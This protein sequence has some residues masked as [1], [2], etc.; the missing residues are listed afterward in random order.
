VVAPEL[1][2]PVVQVPGQGLAILPPAILVARVET[3]GIDRIGSDFTPPFLP[4]PFHFMYGMVNKAVKDMVVAAHGE[5]MWQAIK[6]RASVTQEVFIGNEGYPD[7]LTYALVG[8]ASE[9]LE[10]P[11]PVIL[12]AFG[13]HWVL[14]TAAEGYGPMMAAGGNSLGEFLDNLPHF[15]DRVALIYPKLVPP[16]FEVTERTARSLRLH[17]TSHR[18]GLAPFVEGLVSGLG[19]RFNTPVQVVREQS[20]EETGGDTDIF[21]VSWP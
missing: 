18:G 6:R 8:A 20:R 14:H 10:Q 13:E 9:L 19:K 7:E 2:E 4:P 11:A 15:H 17:Y 3:T 1:P 21:R 5:G 12:H 16:R